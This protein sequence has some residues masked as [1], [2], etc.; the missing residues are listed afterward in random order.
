MS[1]WGAD[2]FSNDDAADFLVEVES[3]RNCWD[4]VRQALL[5]GLS[6]AS[7]QQGARALAAAEFVAT[8]KGSHI[9]SIAEDLVAIAR[10]A[11]PPL[12]DDLTALARRSVVAVRTSSDWRD[13]WAEEDRRSPQDGWLSEWL[14]ATDDLLSRLS[15]A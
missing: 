5:A 12:V 14:A 1:V 8:A 9:A 3:S 2:A 15:S 6:R 11:S 4:T 13:Y 10:T 7:E